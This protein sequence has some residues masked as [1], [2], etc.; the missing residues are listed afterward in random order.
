MKKFNIVTRTTNT[1][2]N[3]GDLKFYWV[4][5]IQSGEEFH[6]D[7]FEECVSFVEE[8]NGDYAEVYHCWYNGR[9]ERM[10]W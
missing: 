1:V 7:T 2:F 6:F 8:E 5:D 4:E 3:D 10:G 9:D